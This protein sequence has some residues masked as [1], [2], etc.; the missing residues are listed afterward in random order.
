MGATR[1]IAVDSLPGVGRWWMNAAISA[2][3]VFRRRRRFPPD[4]DLTIISP[5]GRMGDTNDAVF[6]RRD[7]VDR[8]I[9]MGMRDAEHALEA[10]SSRPVMR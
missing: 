9:A 7:N 5:S 3:H 8:W 1:I 2:A 4:L 10:K 6:W